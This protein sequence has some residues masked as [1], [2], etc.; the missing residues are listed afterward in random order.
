MYPGNINKYMPSYATW[1]KPFIRLLK[2]HQQLMGKSISCI[3]SQIKL[4]AIR[5]A[6]YDVSNINE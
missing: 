2:Y 6:P 4:P 1:D 5:A 3:N